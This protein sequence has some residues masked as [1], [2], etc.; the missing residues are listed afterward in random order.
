MNA[1]HKCCLPRFEPTQRTAFRSLYLGLLL[2]LCALFS[3]AKA[4]GQKDTVP[5]C[6][7]SMLDVSMLPPLNDSSSAP[8]GI[9][10]VTFR[11][12]SASTCI[13]SSVI[14]AL[15]GDNESSQ[16]PSAR[17]V[18]N[19]DEAQ[20]FKSTNHRL[21]PGEQ[22][23]LTL[24]WSGVPAVYRDVAWGGCSTY[25]D[26]TLSLPGNGGP[27]LLRTHHL[28]MR[29]CGGVW[30]SSLRA[31]PFLVNENVPVEWMD[32]YKIKL[33]E[34][35]RPALPSEDTPP[36]SLHTIQP[37]E[38]LKSTFESGYA[39]FMVLLLSEPPAAL[40]TCPF[41]TL[42]RREA[43]GENTIYVNHCTN[44]AH[45]SAAIQNGMQEL[46]LRDYDLLAQ[47][48]GHVEYRMATLTTK[49]DTSTL[50]TAEVSFDVRDPNQPMLPV[51][52][53]RVPECTA[54]QLA[55]S[56]APV[57]LGDHWTAGR[58]ILADDGQQWQDGRAFQVTNNS[59][60]TCRLG[61]LPDVHFVLPGA[62]PSNP[63]WA[64]EICRNC[65]SSLFQP[66]ESE[67]I[68]LRPAASAHFFVGITLLPQR[69]VGNC[70]FLNGAD[71]TIGGTK[72]ARLPFNTAACGQIMVSA[73]R[74]GAYDHDPLNLAYDR[75]LSE[76]EKHFK[77]SLANV[78]ADCRKNVSEETGTPVMFVS[79]G[80]LEWGLATRS[81]AMDK[82]V[83]V[84]VWIHNR[85]DKPVP[86]FTCSDVENYLFSAFD[87]LDSSGRVVL[88]KREA[89][90]RKAGKTLGMRARGVM[91]CDSNVIFEV[92]P[93][94]CASGSLTRPSPFFTMQLA[95]HYAIAPGTFF[96][97]P[98][99]ATPPGQT[100]PATGPPSGLPVSG[101]F[102][103][104]TVTPE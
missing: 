17:A 43:D 49:G 22:A 57:D 23:H 93:H 96:L 30:I 18:D 38:Y 55:A 86:L 63:Y 69:M 34:L 89:E 35:A 58:I 76:Q 15:S 80:D 72:L 60:Q 47:R 66:R 27:T 75:Q 97:V 92:A 41:L 87:V 31:G 37:V 12:R 20:L 2:V 74:S 5:E 64:G 67:W 56:P 24:G 48:A 90:E 83:P 14:A 61:G 95:A 98:T 4:H 33:S 99:P 19:S 52:E 68:D 50:Q 79:R 26:L 40:A 13:L 8:A 101:P 78:P 70:A 32:S 6:T 59:A 7:P 53:T 104:V 21:S 10:A 84:T 85:S 36:L 51:V 25:D 71:V 102:I 28:W 94:S 46:L 100:M 16:F 44:I 1:T 42:Q 103:R 39:E 81:A 88:T 65:A 11:N 91:A 3:G 77:P 45:G 9:F 82:G 29:S 54:S 73:W 62:Q